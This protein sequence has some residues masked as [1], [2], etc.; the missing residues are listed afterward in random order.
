[1][2]AA[3]HPRWLHLSPGK[4]PIAANQRLP[5]VGFLH[6][7]KTGGSTVRHLVDRSGVAGVLF[8][9][10]P[11][12]LQPLLAQHPHLRVACTI[13][14]PIVRFISAFYS[15]R[16]QGRPKRM[17]IWTPGEA[18]AYLWFP[19]VEA[20]VMGF[21]SPDERVKSAALFAKAEI[22]HLAW[23]Y[24]HYYTSAAFVRRNARRFAFIGEIDKLNENLPQ[25][26][27]TM[28]VAEL[29]ALDAAEAHQ[30]A[31]PQKKPELSEEAT[32]I[33]RRILAEDYEIYDAL[34][35]VAATAG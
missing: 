14:D 27:R 20:L 13:R 30:H 23:D 24:P 17:A 10:H 3:E 32:Q 15:R 1:M 22:K 5:D 6:M 31:A 9:G 26:L 4:T 8:L 18:T 2:P 19:D 21:E 11:T 34:R 33:L 28:G 35:D 25:L 12:R 16:R 7:P 29:P